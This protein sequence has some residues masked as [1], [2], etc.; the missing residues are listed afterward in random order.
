MSLL[1]PMISKALV[2][3]I[4][5]THSIMELVPSLISVI[6]IALVV[7]SKAFIIP[8]SLAEFVRQI[9][10]FTRVLAS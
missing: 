3:A 10:Y 6:A 1:G 7:I 2:G 8:Y 4:A 5:A 9:N